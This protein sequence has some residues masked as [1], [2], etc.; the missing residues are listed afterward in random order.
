[1]C[2]IYDP[3]NW[4][5]V[6]GGDDSRV[7]SGAAAGY[8]E[9]DAPGYVAWGESG[10]VATHIASVAELVEVLASYAA[11]VHPGPDANLAAQLAALGA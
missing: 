8:I 7:W 10:N 5:W 11:T 3:R 9:P 2:S 1:M 6:I 4:F